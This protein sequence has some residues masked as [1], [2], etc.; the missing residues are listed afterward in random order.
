MP[1]R[2]GQG[3]ERQTNPVASG[4]RP[5]GPLSPGRVNRL[6][7]QL[8]RIRTRLRAKLLHPAAIDFG[9]IEVAF[10]I[11]A[12]A[13]YAPE[14]AREVA[15]DAPGIQELSVEIVLQHLRCAAIGGPQGTV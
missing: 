15:P 5:A 13:V 2:Q 1:P 9:R 14:A 7:D 10:L 3:R 12:E 8:R 6:A 11:H 4:R